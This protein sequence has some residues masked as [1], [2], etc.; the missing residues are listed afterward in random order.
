MHFL[1]AFFGLFLSLS[2]SAA[3]E[4]GL[5]E[6]S[7]D[8]RYLSLCPVRDDG[9]VICNYSYGFQS[10]AVA[11]DQVNVVAHQQ[12]LRALESLG[13]FSFYAYD[14]AIRKLVPTGNFLMNGFYVKYDSRTILIDF[15]HFHT[16]LQ[17]NIPLSL[18]TTISNVLRVL[19]DVYYAKT[20]RPNP[21]VKRLNH[22]PVLVGR[23]ECPRNGLIITQLNYGIDELYVFT[24]TDRIVPFDFAAND[25]GMKNAADKFVATCNDGTVT[26]D[27]SVMRLLANRDLEFASNGTSMVC[28]RQGLFLGR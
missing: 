9:V 12:N 22:C 25:A 13:A 7:S 3:V 5:F 2:A 19:T 16:P 18:R 20:S 15:A 10:V 27:G 26:L 11:V 1:I 6:K 8:G 24:Y 4:Y 14:D 28:R 17:V 23:Y 21:L